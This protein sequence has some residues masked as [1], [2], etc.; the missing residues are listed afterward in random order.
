LARGARR[1]PGPVDGVAAV[2]GRDGDVVLGH[3]RAGPT[4]IVRP[5]PPAS[6]APS[7]APAAVAAATVASTAVA[8]GR[9]RPV[10]VTVAVTVRVPTVPC[11]PGVP[12]VSVVAGVPSVAAFRRVVTP[13]LT[14]GRTVACPVVVGVVGVV[15]V[16]ASHVLTED[17]A[18]FAAAHGGGWMLMTGSG[19]GGD[20]LSCLRPQLGWKNERR[21]GK[22]KWRLGSRQELCR[23][24]RNE[25]RRLQTSTASIAW[26]QKVALTANPANSTPS[27]AVTGW[28]ERRRYPCGEEAGSPALEICDDRDRG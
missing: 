20:L 17:I 16:V 18:Y 26:E 6:S 7:P 13:A 2:G 11:V 4:E 23:I 27:K 8:A 5:P 3:A 19:G 28:L 25:G 14:R 22:E 21:G 15:A 24:R 10:A 9:V 12:A 1:A